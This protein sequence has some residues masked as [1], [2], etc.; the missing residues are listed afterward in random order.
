MKWYVSVYE[1]PQS[2]FIK[3]LMAQSE[4]AMMRTIEGEPLKPLLAHVAPNGNFN[5]PV[6][7]EC[8]RVG[9][10][11]PTFSGVGSGATFVT[12][13]ED[14]KITAIN[15]AGS[16]SFTDPYVLSPEEP[17]IADRAYIWE[18]TARGFNDWSAKQDEPDILAI[19]RDVARGG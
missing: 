18:S 9:G 8:G 6:V 4:R 11:V 15:V 17:E 13:V 14:G 12:R 5:V 10:E 3:E 1:A 7:P 16:G 19:T 2:E